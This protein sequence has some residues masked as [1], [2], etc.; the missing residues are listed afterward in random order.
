MTQIISVITKD[1]VL[2]ASDRRLTIGAGPRKGELFDDDTCKLVS[3][4]NTCGIA[5]SGLA[6]ISGIPTHEWIAKKLAAADCHDASSASSVITNEANIAFANVKPSIRRH[7]FLMAGWAYFDNPPVLRSHFCAITNI[8]DGSGKF[9]SKPQEKFDY[10][11]RALRDN[12]QFLWYSI[13]EPLRS[14]RAK[15]LERNLRQLVKR[16]I[17]PKEALRILV[18]EIVYKSTVEKCQTVGSKILGYCIP[19]QAV[20]KQ[21]KSQQWFVLAQQPN[22]TSAAFTYFEPEYK[23]LRQYGPTVVCGNYAVTDI[24]T[25]NDEG[26]NYQSSQMRILHMPGR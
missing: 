1:Y 5:Y 25:E 11:V 16:D 19:K 23:E 26:R 21:E 2:L 12:E 8:L 4:C 15:Y 7:I 9:V 6:H 3:L 14:E 24:K 18:E 17:G 20:N 10:I 13:G 22:E